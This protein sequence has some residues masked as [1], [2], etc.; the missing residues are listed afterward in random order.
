MLI[1][2]AFLV[3]LFFAMNIGGS[4]AAASMGIAYG[5]GAI[6]HKYVA[7]ILCALG[8]FLGAAIGSE[9]VIKTI[10]SG[11][12]PT[13]LL[14]LELII[15][16]LASACVTLFIA[17][18]L[19]IPLSTSEVTVGSI[20][21]VGFA[22]Q[23]VFFHNLFHIVIWWLVTPIIA[24]VFSFFVGRLI[25]KQKTRLTQLLHKYYHTF[26]YFVIGM[27]FLEAFS[28]G[29]NNAANAIGPL[30]GAGVLSIKQGMILGG[31]FVALGVI[32]LGH[33]TIETNGK[34]ITSLSLVQGVSVSGTSAIIVII[35]SLFGIP[36]PMTQ[37]TTSGILGIGAS[38]HGLRI[39][40]RHIIKKIIAIWLV[41]PLL[42]LT[43]AYTL[44]QLMIEN[45][46]YSS[47]AIMSVLFSTVGTFM[48]IKIVKNEQNLKQRRI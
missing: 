3:A 14:S 33:R 48:L 24:F 18:I 39:F 13:S 42:S 35:A 28:A 12:I 31:A 16:I 47:L 36:V 15:V 41:S 27:G 5:S 37:I 26:I 21:G 20:V 45:N 11:L 44:V 40:Q 19:G 43:I 4:G 29:M 32:F 38:N 9:K 46:L 2:I 23:T 1:A 7:L 6:K 25:E 8:I 10:G 30:V 17:N 22:Y 34:K